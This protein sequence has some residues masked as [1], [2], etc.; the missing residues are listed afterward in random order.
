MNL[1]LPNWKVRLR[2]TVADA[3]ICCFCAKF[4]PRRFE[5][6]GTSLGGQERK[7]LND[8][9]IH[10]QPTLGNAMQ[11]SSLLSHKVSP[12]K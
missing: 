3:G 10:W 12:Q 5:T 4:Y 1:H 11:F 7:F 6:D 9:R 2:L 8:D